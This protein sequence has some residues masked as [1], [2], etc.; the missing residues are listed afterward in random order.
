VK[1]SYYI[2]SH[3]K[4]VE[5]GIQC[6]TKLFD[7]NPTKIIPVERFGKSMLDEY[8]DC[9][10]EFDEKNRKIT[11]VIPPGKALWVD[12][13]TNW[14]G[15]VSEFRFC[16]LALNKIAIE[17]SGKETTYEGLELLKAFDKYH[18]NPFNDSLYAIIID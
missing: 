3:D 7:F 18:L 2:K 6:P 8:P 4:N 10:Y 17:Q 16:R 13:T 9:Q 11:M 15:N 1:I 14:S 12:R 5:S